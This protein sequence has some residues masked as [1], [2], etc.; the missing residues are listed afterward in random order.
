MV[1]MIIDFHTHTHHSYDSLM[2][3]RKIIRIAKARGLDGI[4]TCDHNT[5]KG[6]VEA[7]KVNDDKDFTVIVGAEIA[8]DVGDIIG[9]FLTKEI[10]S[11]KFHKVVKEIKQQGGKVI[12]SHPF[13]SHD[14]SKIDFSKIDFIEGYNARLNKKLNQKARKLANKY[15]KPIVAGSDSHLYGEI[16]NCKTVVENLKTIKPIKCKYKQSK[17]IFITFSQYIKAWKKKNVIVLISATKIL[18]KYF[19]L[20]YLKSPK[21]AFIPSLKNEKTPNE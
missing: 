16:A 11:R 20:Q 10:E 21:T 13:K 2:K 1:E 17:Q 15:N 3:P 4:V 14:L 9:I 19:V 6:G 7:Q 8:T 18:L 5:I 12:L